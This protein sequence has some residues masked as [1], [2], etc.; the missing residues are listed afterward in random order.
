MIL[1]LIVFA[2]SFNLNAKDE[3]FKEY[4]IEGFGIINIPKNME[5]QAGNYKEMVDSYST[6]FIDGYESDGTVRYVF[7]QGGLNNFNKSALKLYSRI[8][9]STDFDQY[10]SYRSLGSHYKPTSY[11]AYQIEQELRNELNDIGA[12]I[13]SFYGAESVK[14]NNQSAVKV[15]YLRQLNNNPPVLVDIYYFE[16]NDRFHRVTM[17]YRKSEEKLWKP[18]LDESLH[19]IR[20]EKR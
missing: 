14:I 2:I 1:I 3:L 17:S 9:I 4:R 6:S 7:Q 20:I 5:L 18:L 19:S 10:G 8:I 13:I 12:K 11:E 16:N 15:S